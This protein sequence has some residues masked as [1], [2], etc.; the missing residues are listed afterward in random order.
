MAKR[1]KVDLSVDPGN[2]NKCIVSGSFEAS[3]GDKVVFVFP[4]APDAEITFVGNSP[5][6]QM[7]FPVGTQVVRPHA[8]VR[9]YGY[10][11]QWGSG[12]GGVGNGG[13]EVHP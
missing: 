11:V 9:S 3:P 1:L 4:D 12:G 8:A 2:K 13:G 7:T 10:I 5:F 6:N